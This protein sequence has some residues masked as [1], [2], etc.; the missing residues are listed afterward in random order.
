[1][2]YDS[3]SQLPDSVRGHLP[4][5]AQEIYRKVF[6]SAWDE[7]ADHRDREALAHKVAWSIVKQ[8]YRKQGDRW[9]RRRE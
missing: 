1:V 8:R 7:Y 3:I 9:V 2:P 4:K 5:A 6:N